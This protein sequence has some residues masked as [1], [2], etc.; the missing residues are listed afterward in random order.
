[1]SLQKAGPF[2]PSDSQRGGEVAPPLLDLLLARDD[3]LFLLK[4]LK[5]ALHILRDH[6]LLLFF[7]EEG[8]LVEQGQLGGHQAGQ[9]L[10]EVSLQR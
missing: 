10:L 5:Q 8:E 2:L 4:H 9:H 7:H 1:M 6:P 3:I